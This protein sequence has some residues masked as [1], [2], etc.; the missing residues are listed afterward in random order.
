M[1]KPTNGVK[2]LLKILKIIWVPTLVIF[3]FFIGAY[4]G[5]QFMTKTPGADVF[6]LETWKSFFEQ[7]GSLR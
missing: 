6:S 3:A 5:Y 1:A 7:I 4:I 2:V